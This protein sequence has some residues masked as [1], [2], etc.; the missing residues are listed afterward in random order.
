MEN[1]RPKIANDRQRKQCSREITIKTK[2]TPHHPYLRMYCHVLAARIVGE[3]PVFRGK[4]RFCKKDTVK[5]RKE[6]ERLFAMMRFA[7]LREN[8][9]SGKR[10]GSR[11][12]LHLKFPVYYPP[13]GVAPVRIKLPIGQGTRTKGERSTYL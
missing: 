7:N 11:I 9:D 5:R 4:P 3:P 10:L 6:K 1:A 2:R 12:S 13:L 8:R